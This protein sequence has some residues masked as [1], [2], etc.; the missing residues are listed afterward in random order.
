MV[1]Q[2]AEGNARAGEILIIDVEVASAGE[3]ADFEP[4][5]CC[6]CGNAKVSALLDPIIIAV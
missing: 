6:I 1:S 5:F 4:Q 2:Y 3:E